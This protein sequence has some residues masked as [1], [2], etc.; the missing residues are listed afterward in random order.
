MTLT[1][2]RAQVAGVGRRDDANISLGPI[3]NRTTPR[4]VA[5]VLRTAILDGTLSPES[6]LREARIASD[7][8]VSRAPLREALGILADEGLVDKI[9]YKGA[10]VAEANAK[11]I[12]QIAG[13]RKRLEPFAIELAMPRLAGG[14]RTRVVHALQEMSRGADGANLAMTIEGHMSFHRAF[15]ELSEHDLLIDLW[16]SWEG[17]LQLFLSVDHQSFANL[18]DVVAEHERL[19][20]I[21][22]TGDL[23]AIALEM[24]RHVHDQI[25]AG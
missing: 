7:L 17:Q 21:I 19:L 4:T 3:E 9:A 15:Y 24:D 22:D 12:A 6:P 1:A 20:A 23:E 13:L 25:E 18:H 8:G 10:Y 2:N 16:H 11:K 14:G 5:N